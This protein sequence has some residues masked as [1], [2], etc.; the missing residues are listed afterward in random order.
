MLPLR[1]ERPGRRR[2]RLRRR[3]DQQRRARLV[4][5][6]QVVEIAVLPV[7]VEVENRLFGSEQNSNAAVEL[8]GEG[9]TTRVIGRG[10]L[11]LESVQA[12][13]NKQGGE[14]SENAGA[15]RI[16]EA[17]VGHQPGLQGFARS[18]RPRWWRRDA[19]NANRRLRWVVANN[20]IGKDNRNDEQRGSNQTNPGAITNWRACIAWNTRE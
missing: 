8:A 10:G 4:P 12:G 14:Q 9:H 20:V 11:L 15:Q 7:G 6:G 13:H 19:D 3:G 1:I 16:H 17:I 18:Y 2:R 5:A